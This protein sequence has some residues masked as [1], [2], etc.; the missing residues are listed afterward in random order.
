MDFTAKAE[1]KSDDSHVFC[2]IPALRSGEQ[3]RNFLTTVEIPCDNVTT[4]GGPPR[5][6]KG[7]SKNVCLDG[8]FD[9]IPGRCVVFSFG[10]NH[11]WSF[12][13]EMAEFGCKRRCLL[14]RVP[15]ARGRVAALGCGLISFCNRIG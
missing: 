11:D 13:D 14:A 2:P 3:F 1:E 7:S 10:I 15:F 9:V 5:G 6:K 8:R 12:E 4:F